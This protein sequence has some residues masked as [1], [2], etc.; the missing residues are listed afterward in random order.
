[1]EVD[2]NKEKRSPSGID[3]EIIKRGFKISFIA[4]Q[5]DKDDP[6]LHGWVVVHIWM[7]G[8]DL[9]RAMVNMLAR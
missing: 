4:R 6:S 3:V 1:M 8:M 7:M 5:F 2:I 9:H